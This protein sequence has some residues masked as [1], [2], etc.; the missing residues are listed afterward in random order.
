[1]LQHGQDLVYRSCEHASPAANTKTDSTNAFVYHSTTHINLF[2]C[3]TVCAY[4][5]T[6]ADRMHA[7]SLATSSIDAPPSS[8][9]KLIANLYTPLRI[10]YF[11]CTCIECANSVIRICA[12]RRSVATYSP[13]GDS[14]RGISSLSTHLCL[15]RTLRNRK[16]AY[17]WFPY[18]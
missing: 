8:S 1:M 15:F 4:E 13:A 14:T 6:P 10:R 7:A 2:T 11:V 9:C 5:A 18:R 17:Q 12:K 16:G 3:C